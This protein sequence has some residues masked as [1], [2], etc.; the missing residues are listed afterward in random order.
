MTAA[1]LVPGPVTVRVPAKVN[2]ELLVGPRR[3]DGYHSLATVY[4]AVGLYDDVTLAAAEDF[5]V[6]VGG[7]L[8]AGVPTNDE[9]IALRAARLLAERYNYNGE[10]RAVGDVLHDQIQLMRRCGITAFVVKHEPTRKA[11]SEGKLATV[12]LFYQPVGKTE[13]PVGTRP[14]LRRAVETV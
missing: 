5:G 11:L 4:Q 9:N 2:L 7:P 10:I 8:A 6:S 12:D 14:F 1:P 3:A 13:I